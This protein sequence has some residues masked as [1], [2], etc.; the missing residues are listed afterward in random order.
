MFTAALRRRTHPV[1]PVVSILFCLAASSLC[2]SWFAVAAFA[3]QALAPSVSLADPDGSTSIHVQPGDEFRIVLRATGF[4]GLAGFDAHVV[5]TGPVALAASPTLGEWFA[6]GRDVFDIPSPDGCISAILMQPPEISGGGDLAVFTLRAEADG[7][8]TVALDAA[9]LCLARADGQRI[10]VDTPP[11]VTV[12][13]GDGLQSLAGE[14]MLASA[15][16]QLE[17]FPLEGDGEGGGMMMM[18]LEDDAIIV[19]DVNRDNNVNILDVITV[20]NNIGQDPLSSVPLFRCDVNG[21]SQINILDMIVVRDHIGLRELAMLRLSH[22]ESFIETAASDEPPADV[23][24]VTTEQDGITHV[25]L[26]I[27]GWHPSELTWTAVCAVPECQ[28]CAFEPPD[29]SGPTLDLVFTHSLAWQQPEAHSVTLTVTRLD[30]GEIIGARTALVEF[31][32]EHAFI[33]IP[34]EIE[35]KVYAA[36]DCPVDLTLNLAAAC[37]PGGTFTW[38]ADPNVAVQQNEGTATIASDTA[39]T[40]A[41]VATY[42]VDEQSCHHEFELVVFEVRYVSAERP[43]G[44]ATTETTSTDIFAKPGIVTVQIGRAHV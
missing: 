41:V 29:F 16:A 1:T 39:G 17:L 10:I 18:G 28:C 12:T 37:P 31:D 13:I 15:M 23:L 3:E 2:E 43:D 35:G 44:E 24:E 30:D 33:D 32:D 20:R 5:L 4:E 6:G 25:S 26:R 38:E 11:C 40:Y 19:G 42:T 36:K 9:S 14:E 8:G 22:G 21:D 7:I 34:E 27:T